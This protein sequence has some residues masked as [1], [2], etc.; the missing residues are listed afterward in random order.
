[1]NFK[2]FVEAA[3]TE[4]GTAPLGSWW[5]SAVRLSVSD[6]KPQVRL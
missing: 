2:S 1:M 4:R 6:G 3:W 5:D